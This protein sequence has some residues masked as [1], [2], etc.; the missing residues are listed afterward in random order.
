MDSEK[1]VSCCSPSQDGQSKNDSDNQHSDND[2]NGCNP[3][4]S[5]HCCSIA[6][7]LMQPLGIARIATYQAKN[8]NYFEFIPPTVI[9]TIW[10][11]P[12]IS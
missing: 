7:S 10:Q 2:C 1:A 8:I 4:A 6:F 5:C 12:K 11:P 9:F 3:L